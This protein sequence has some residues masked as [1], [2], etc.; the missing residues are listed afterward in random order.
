[1]EVVLVPWTS[2][3]KSPAGRLRTGFAKLLVLMND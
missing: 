2:G 3:G 1:V